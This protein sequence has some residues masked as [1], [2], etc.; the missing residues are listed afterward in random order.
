MCSL[1]KT[2]EAAGCG[3]VSHES[4]FSNINEERTSDMTVFGA[5]EDGTN[6][7]PSLQ[8]ET[9]LRTMLR[10]HRYHK[11]FNLRDTP[12]GMVLDPTQ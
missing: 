2:H 3:P 5:S 7:R 12:A 10:A 9:H 11:D 6:S 1:V 8:R 4:I